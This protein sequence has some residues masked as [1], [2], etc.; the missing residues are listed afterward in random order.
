MAASRTRG[1]DCHAPRFA[2][3]RKRHP[4][5]PIQKRAERWAGNLRKLL[6]QQQHGSRVMTFR[7]KAA[8]WLFDSEPTCHRNYPKSNSEG[9]HQGQVT[10]ITGP[11]PL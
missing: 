7:V 2:H 5:S 11:A 9:D 4:P 6:P 3:P 1:P 10:L 8:G